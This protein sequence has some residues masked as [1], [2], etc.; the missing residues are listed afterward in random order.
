MSIK[1]QV[2]SS[3]KSPL[4]GGDRRWS[5][6]RNRQG[7]VDGALSD[8]TARSG[9]LTPAEHTPRSPNRA[10][11]FRFRISPLKR[12][13]FMAV[14]ILVAILMGA[15]TTTV[16]AQGTESS[17]NSVNTPQTES[18][19]TDSVISPP[20]GVGTRKALAGET[21]YPQ[22]ENYI[23]IAIE[24]NPELRS[25]HHL[26]EAE[27]ERAREVGVLPDP[28][29]NIM[30]DFNPMMSESQLGRFSVS[31]M[32]MFPW[33]GSLGT[34]RDAQRAMAEADRAQIDVRQLEILRDLQIA[35]FEIADVEQQIRIVNDQIELVRELETLVEI[36]YETG[37]AAQADILRIQMEEARLQN[38]IENLED[39][40]IPLKAGFNEFLN[41]PADSDVETTEQTETQE[42]L[43]SDDQI[44]RMV[45]AENP[46]FDGIESR[47][48]ALDQQ[49]RVAQLSGR[50]SFGLG[51]EVMGRDFGPMSMFPDA[52]ESFIG[53]ATVRLPI[54]R[55]RT[56]SQQQQ[57]TS[58]KR[59][60]DS[61]LLQTENRLSSEV[62]SALEELRK[63]ERNLRLLDEELVPRAQQAL[64]ILTDEYTVGRARFDELLQIQRELL[65]FEIERIE[66]VVGQNKAVVRI[67][68]LIGNSPPLKGESATGAGG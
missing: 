66:A 24:E 8:G 39:Q 55:S 14:L 64:D 46:R 44:H 45:R 53:M 47:S 27:K 37:G 63:S 7:W 4:L 35:W 38:R 34:M 40:L 30:Y 61:E 26:Y 42:V 49:Q 33:F 3:E 15:F 28:E 68:S 51:L 23:Q 41:R 32:Q 62:E 11:R 5:V 48:N 19:T 10:S 59:A 17:T 16:Y 57:I 58:R 18:G 2:V 43:Y 31:A 50:P 9:R 20:R 6:Q 22:L 67:I 25:L 29:L 21:A 54:F 60:L 52:R 1:Y 65:D 36:R 56:N 13:F 12:G